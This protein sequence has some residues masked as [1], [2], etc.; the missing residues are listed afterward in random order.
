MSFTN[1]ILNAPTISWFWRKVASA[2]P[3]VFAP[4]PYLR[5]SELSILT[6]PVHGII[7][8]TLYTLYVCCTACRPLSKSHD[9]S[10]KYLF[11]CVSV[12]TPSR[13][14]RCLCHRSDQRS[15]HSYKTVMIL[16]LNIWTVRLQLVVLLRGKSKIMRQTQLQS[17]QA[18]W[19]RHISEAVALGCLRW[20]YSQ[21]WRNTLVLNSEIG[22]QCQR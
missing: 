18:E 8:T 1:H 3:L 6:G 15:R 2:K 13:S 12:C 11:V 17:L 4:R 5:M 20:S 19:A 7:H 10:R 16:V 9:T 21:V 22:T 14:L